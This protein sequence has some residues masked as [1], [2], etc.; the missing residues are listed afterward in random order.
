MTSYCCY[1]FTVRSP[2][3]FAWLLLSK[4]C[5][6][7]EYMSAFK[8]ALIS[9]QVG[10]EMLKIFGKKYLALSLVWG[11][12]WVCARWVDRQ[13]PQKRYFPFNISDS[14]AAIFLVWIQTERQGTETA[15]NIEKVKN[16]WH[17]KAHRRKEFRRNAAGRK[18]CKYLEFSYWLSNFRSLNPES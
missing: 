18:L 5:I 15:I 6:S 8:W 11:R 12:K 14:R 7:N 17:K 10:L 1:Y 2:F 4:K 16:K 3:S 13:M 9:F